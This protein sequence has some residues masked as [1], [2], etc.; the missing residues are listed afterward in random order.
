MPTS[1]TQQPDS[2]CGATS[3]D[4]ERS[5]SSSS[6]AVPGHER[7]VEVPSLATLVARESRR[8]VDAV[9]VVDA[10]LEGDD[11]L[12]IVELRPQ[13]LELE[14]VGHQTG[15]ERRV[16]LE[17]LEERAAQTLALVL[18]DVT[19]AEGLRAQVVVR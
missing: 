9:G 15:V 7:G 18:G 4:Y 13:L 5:G 11:E 12:G 1:A 6:S 16:E 3:T 19:L 8:A 10:A 14:L 2:D 17:V